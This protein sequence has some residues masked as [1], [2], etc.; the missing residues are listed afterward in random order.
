MEWSFD[1]SKDLTTNL[2]REPLLLRE[3]VYLAPTLRR[4]TE[5]YLMVG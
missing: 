3:H 2:W 4:E 1:R 5:N